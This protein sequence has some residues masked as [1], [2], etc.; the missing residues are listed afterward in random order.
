MTPA[1]VMV[2]QAGREPLVS[3]QVYGAIPPEPVKATE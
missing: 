1:D 3:F 2:K